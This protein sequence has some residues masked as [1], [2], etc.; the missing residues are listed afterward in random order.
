M[1]QQPDGPCI[2][3]MDLAA[4]IS[5]QSNGAWISAIEEPDD[6]KAQIATMLSA[7][8]CDGAEEYAIFDHDEFYGIDI[9]EN[10]SIA[11]VHQKALF[12]VEHGELG[13]R[14]LANHNGDFDAAINTLE[15][16]CFTQ[17][18]SMKQWAQDYVANE[19]TTPEIL[20]AHINY[21]SL[22]KAMLLELNMYCIETSTGVIHLF[23][24]C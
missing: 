2:Y 7:S 15:N 22:G 17:V 23:H 19:I 21:H 13:A 20:L 1:S 24:N 4:Y 8:P 11:S 5:G 3:V 18:D 16:C 6:V 14:V 9:D 12:V 10:E